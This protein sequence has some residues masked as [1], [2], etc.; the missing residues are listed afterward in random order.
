MLLQVHAA[1]QPMSSSSD[2]FTTT[3]AWALSTP[4]YAQMRIVPTRTDTAGEIAVHD[5]NGT[6]TPYHHFRVYFGYAAAEQASSRSDIE[7]KMDNLPEQPKNQ[8]G[9]QSGDCIRKGCGCCLG[10]LCAIC[11]TKA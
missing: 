1:D 5:W 11:E 10:H 7:V 4:T 8:H 3:K 9:I 2:T 6:W